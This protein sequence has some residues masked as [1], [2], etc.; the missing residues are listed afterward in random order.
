MYEGADGDA[1]AESLAEVAPTAGLLDRLACERL[2]ATGRLD[3]V[4]AWERSVRHAQ[5]GLTRALG[6]LARLEGEEG[7]RIED[8]VGAALAW[9]PSTAQNRLIEAEVLTRLFPA[10]VRLL[11]E[12]RI[13]MQQARSLEQLTGGL[14]DAAAQAVEARVLVRMAGQSASL[15]R[16]AIRRAVVR[17]DPHAAA[18]RHRHERERRRV[19][20]IPE[21]D[22]MATLNFY[23]PADVAQMAMRTL[24]E[25][26]HSAKRKAKDG[27]DK[28]TL[29]QRRADLLPVLLHHAAT[30]GTFRAAAKPAIPE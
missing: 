4:V 5:A 15:T 1:L 6:A 25:L 10:T 24:T 13:S 18:K 27:S 9:A 2:S 3:A 12:G 7:W 20:L 17:A 28:R 23:L 11:G 30:G 22:G 14:E 21:D 26:A 19:E 16:Q 29:D 8:E